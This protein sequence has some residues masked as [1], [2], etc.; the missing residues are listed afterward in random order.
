MSSNDNK[1][2]DK[3]IIEHHENQ[4]DS[5]P[6]VI[7]NAIKYP[8]GYP[9]NQQKEQ[10]KKNEEKHKDSHPMHCH[11]MQ[12]MQSATNALFIDINPDYNQQTNSKK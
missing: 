5:S 9:D 11:H 2:L 4:N 7:I 8:P 6:E 12:P 10:C 3:S 1:K